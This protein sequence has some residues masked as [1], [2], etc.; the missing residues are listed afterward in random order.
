MQLPDSAVGRII[1]ERYEILSPLSEGGMGLLYVA[2]QRTLKRKVALKLIRPGMTSVHRVADRFLVEAQSASQLN[3]PNVVSIYDFGQTTDGAHTE[4]FLVMELLSGSDLRALIESNVPLAPSHIVDILRQTL[5]GLAEAHDHGITHRDIKPENIFLEHR[6]RG[7]LVKLIDFGVARVERDVSMTLAGQFVGTPAYCAPEQIR[8][9]AGPSVDLYAVG[10]VLYELLTGELPFDGPSAVQ[11]LVKH[12]SSPRPDPAAHANGRDVPRALADVC[13]RAMALDPAQRFPTAEAMSDALAAA[14]EPQRTSA[15]RGSMFPRRARRSS[16]PAAAISSLPPQLSA[17]EGFGRIDSVL[18]AARVVPWADALPLIGRAEELAWIV[19]AVLKLEPCVL[20]Y[21]RPGVGRSRL[22]RAASERLAEAG[23]V[24]FGIQA[25]TAPMNEVGDC[26]LRDLV[27]AL[28]GLTVDALASGAAAAEPAATGLRSLFSSRD[29][30]H[31]PT[32]DAVAAA[33]TWALRFAA[34]RAGG[35]PVAI[36]VD[37]V[38]HLDGGA[39]LAIGDAL[40]HG[41][42][43]VS[44]VMTSLRPPH[45]FENDGVEKRELFGFGAEELALWRESVAKS[46]ADVDALVLPSRAGIEP[47]Y[48]EHVWFHL[49]DDP[50]PDSLEELVVARV[51]GLL[52]AERRVLQALAVTGAA[53]DTMLASVLDEELHEGTLAALCD[54]R[55]VDVNE[56]VATIKHRII[57]DS[58]LALSP[59]GTTATLHS[60]AADALADDPSILE[61]RAHHSVRGHANFE[62]FL[63]VEEATRRRLGRGDDDGAIALLTSG[64]EAAVTQ[65]RRG[66][67]AAESA[68]AVFA[69]KIGM[70]LTNAGR[71]D[72]GIDV[73]EMALQS[74]N[75]GDAEKALALEQLAIAY[76][77]VGRLEQAARLQAEALVCAQDR[78]DTSMI[79]RLTG[80]PSARPSQAAPRL[81][82]RSSAIDAS[83]AALV[84]GPR[85]FAVSERITRRHD[86]RR[87]DD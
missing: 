36:L 49:E 7:D 87:E 4:L 55:L 75:I 70:A 84:G 54:A 34:S 32:R 46:G 11:I 81:A 78:G 52:P 14:V 3:H 80:P 40:Q 48:L 2:L 42:A 12:Q 19:R 33:L 59:A 83:L 79:R 37:D 71:F 28:T 74:T 23:V 17:I 6:R 13:L 15:V 50:P 41:G 57:A 67:V 63:L 69:R 77:S 51:S 60:R 68:R 29:A 31:A 44:F 30:P 45:R 76:A 62:T 82:F 5:A 64:L 22:L 85:A 61:L 16:V 39:M 65:S 26:T 72:E 66:D 47:L 56:G 1:A 8:G 10:V 24:V 35:R 73:L 86:P 9:E 58:V 21:G 27:A 38:D 25:P 18:P 53:T 20:V 43:P